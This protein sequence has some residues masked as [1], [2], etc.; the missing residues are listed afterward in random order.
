MQKK[1]D[2]FF[3]L[4][5]F[6]ISL[7]LKGA[8]FEVGASKPYAT[9][10]ALYNAGVLSFGDTIFIDG[11][12]YTGSDALAVWSQDNLFIQGV[13]GKP[14]LEANGQYIWGKGIWVLAG[15]DI[16]VDNI[17]FS[18][19][20]VPDQNGAGIRLDGVGLTVTNC[21]FHDN[22]NGILTGNPGTGDIIIEHTEFNHNG[23]GD[24][25]THNIYVGHVN[26]LVFRY[27][28]SHHANIGHNLKSRA[29]ENIIMYNRIMDEDTGNSSRLIDLPNGGFSI[30]MG[31]NLMQGPNAPNN[32][33]IGY[34][35]EGLTNPINELY[36]INNTM[37]NKRTASCV[38]LDIQSGTSIA[39]VSNNIFAGTG[40]VISENAT[41]TDNLVEPDIAN[42]MLVDEANYDYHL[43]EGSPAI[44]GGN[45]V[46][47]A[48][49]YSLTPD[50]SYMHPLSSEPRNIVSS[51]DIGAYEYQTLSAVHNPFFDTTKIYPNPESNLVYIYNPLFNGQVHIKIYNVVGQLIFYKN[52]SIHNGSVSINIQGLEKGIYYIE[53]CNYHGN[54][55]T[56]S[57]LIKN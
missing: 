37:V 51:I 42:V 11:G 38:F 13:N 52:K 50:E 4:S 8:V 28:Y 26:K 1:Y 25:Y 45:P 48:G 32:N 54:I 57:K 33:L 12:M 20:T 31:N 43:M 6:F 49:G 18:G 39:Q 24:G 21:Y 5:L 56:V 27:N 55:K 14:H 29:A 2:Y 47:D 16:T 40:T 9:P 22:E 30:I 17:E 23:Y 34:G 10:N 7:T 15:D 19:A 35:L 44:D 53:I 3:L 36:V 41:M 46:P